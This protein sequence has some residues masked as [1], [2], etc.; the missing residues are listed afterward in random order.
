MRRREVSIGLALLLTTAVLAGLDLQWLSTYRYPV[1]SPDF[2]VYYLAARIGMSHGWAAMYDPSI[3][4]AVESR[5]VGRPLAYLNPPELAWLVLPLTSLP[6]AVAAWVW[7]GLLA[8]G[9]L[10]T[11]LVASPGA[12]WRK[13]MHG[14]TA[15]VLLPIFISVVFGQVS[16]LIVAAVAISWLFI[17]RGQPWLAGVALA[18][19][20]LKPQI[21]FLV[22]PALL[23]AGY[24]RVFLAWS[25][26]T[27]ALATAA[28]LAAGPAMVDLGRRA[29]A[30]VAH[31]PG[32]IQ[33]SLERQL[34]LPVAVVA[35][36]VAVGVAT[37]LVM[38]SRRS[39]SVPI[40]IALVASVLVSPYINFYDLSAVML[41]GWLVLRTHPG[42][43]I[44]VA[45][46]AL[47]PFVYLAPILPLLTLAGLFGW[48]M[49]MVTSK[50]GETMT[51]A[52]RAYDDSMQEGQ[53]AA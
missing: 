2:F 18:F 8:S 43:S 47:Y 13:V 23:L 30:S 27:L 19:I 28:F 38:H 10:L 5:I 15:L 12:G 34:P 46:L 41:A 3:F 1:A 49:T 9:A 26:A 42:R 21:A 4:L 11:W 52:S 51:P 40:A 53:V 7:R 14:T 33:M 16:I 29:L 44:R 50:F 36:L 22:P 45:T 6:Y 20:F 31:V 37:F 39:A 25:L 17:E 48:Q 35:V 32:P 24:R